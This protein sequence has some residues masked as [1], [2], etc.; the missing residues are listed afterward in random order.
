MSTSTRELGEEFQTITAG[1][2]PKDLQSKL[3]HI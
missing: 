1:K 3:L 2:K